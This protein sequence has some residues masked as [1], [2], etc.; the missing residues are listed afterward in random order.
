M[1]VFFY[2]FHSK[3]NA[4]ST[5][6]MQKAQIFSNENM[7]PIAFNYMNCI[8]RYF[9]DQNPRENAINLNNFRNLLYNNRNKTFFSY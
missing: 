8:Q 9:S 7:T 2:E 5:N 6:I 1:Y 4:K 3:Y